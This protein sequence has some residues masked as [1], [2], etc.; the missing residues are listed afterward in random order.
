MIVHQ[1]G[2][3]NRCNWALPIVIEGPSNTMNYNTAFA[4][5]NRVHAKIAL[6][7]ASHSSPPSKRARAEQTD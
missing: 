3:L 7:I 6:K 1:L 5:H 2:D 4:V